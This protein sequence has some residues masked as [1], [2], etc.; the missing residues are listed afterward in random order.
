[1]DL[2]QKLEHAHKV[3]LTDTFILEKKQLEE[4]IK[5]AIENEAK[6]KH[7]SAIYIV[8]MWKQPQSLSTADCFKKM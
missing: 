5:E 3:N 7:S 1:M 6:I 2:Q 8:K 4:R